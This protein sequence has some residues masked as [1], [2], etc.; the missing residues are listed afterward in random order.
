MTNQDLLLGGLVILIYNNLFRA[1][2]GFDIGIVQNT[3]L[4][5]HREPRQAPR[6][7]TW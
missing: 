6:R 2:K 5:Q 7:R 1:K 3:I 4:E